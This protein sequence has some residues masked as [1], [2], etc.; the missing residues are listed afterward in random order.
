M[1]GCDYADMFNKFINKEGKFNQRVREDTNLLM[2]LYEASQLC[3]GGED[4]LDE[5]RQFSSKLLNE[6]MSYLVPYQANIV[7]NTLLYPYHRSSARFMAKNFFLS[8]F[9]G[10]NGWIHVFQELAK[11]DFYLVQS[12]HQREIVQISK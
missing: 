2:G 10:E 8:N 9:Q 5:A 1:F 3:I 4:V 6:S 7:R 12:L 11:M